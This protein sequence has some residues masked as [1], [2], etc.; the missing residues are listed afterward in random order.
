MLKVFIFY[1]NIVS[2]FFSMEKRTP[3]MDILFKLYE[4]YF[5]DSIMLSARSSS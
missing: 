3:P 4:F 2:Y 1:E 5:M